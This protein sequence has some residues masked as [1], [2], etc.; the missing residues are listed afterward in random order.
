[1][2]ISDTDPLGAP[3]IERT[4]PGPDDPPL[5][6]VGG[7]LEEVGESQLLLQDGDGP[8]VTIER[9]SG[10]ATRFYRPEAGD[11]RELSTDEIASIGTGNEACIEALLD[12][13]TLLAIRVFLDRTC[14]PV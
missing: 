2:L 1:M 5:V 9:F 12:G 14:A 8:Q 11:W 6:W 10:E 3:A 4:Q 7:S 13:E